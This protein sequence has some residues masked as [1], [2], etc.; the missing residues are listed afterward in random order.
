MASY[1]LVPI[2]IAAVFA[3]LG[4]M[5]LTIGLLRLRLSRGWVA[6][7]GQVVDRHG[8]TTRWPSRYSTFRWRDHHGREHHRTSLVYASLGPRPGTLVEVKYDP[9]DPSRAVI[10]SVVQSG[11]IFIVIGAL[12]LVMAILLGGFAL[13]L[14]TVIAGSD[15]GTVSPSAADPGLCR[16]LKADMGTQW[17]DACWVSSAACHR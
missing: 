7:T 3:L 2:L 5:F 15:L 10:D 11:R 12:L 16:A 6:T 14:M 1:Q 8:G 13:V 17:R 4:V 9:V